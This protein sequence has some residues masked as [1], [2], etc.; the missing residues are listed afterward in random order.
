[1]FG[2]YFLEEKES[3][4]AELQR[5]LYLGGQ[6]GIGINKVYKAIEISK[7]I[8]GCNIKLFIDNI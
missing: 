7:Y 8:C 3:R 1:M 5:Y 4:S 2:V 6:L